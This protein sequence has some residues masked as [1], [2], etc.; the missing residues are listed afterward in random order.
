MGGI[1][2]LAQVLWT[3]YSENYRQDRLKKNIK[4]R[5]KTTW[6]LE[7]GNSTEEKSQMNCKDEGEAMAS[8]D[9]WSDTDEHPVQTGKGKHW[10]PE[11]TSPILKKKTKKERILSDI[12]IVS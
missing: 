12:L 1:S 6:D 8:G 4:S 2:K 5:S 9:N 7:T 10:L 11:G 3:S